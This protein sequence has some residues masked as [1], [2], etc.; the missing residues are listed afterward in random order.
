MTT[1]S[2]RAGV[3]AITSRWRTVDVDKR[4]V[5]HHRHLTGQL[6]QQ[7]HRTAQH[8]VEVDTGLQEA[9]DRPPLGRRQRLDVVDAV[10]ELAVALLGGHPPG[11]GVRLGDVAL[12]L[13][14]RHVVADG[15]AGHAQ[16]VPVDEGL[17]TDRFLG[18]DEVGNDGAQHLEATVVSTS[19]RLPPP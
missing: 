10:D 8:V 11:A 19:H 13:Q 18:G 7:P 3:T 9:L 6:S 14:H 4:R 16:V 12:G 2:S 17:R 15:G 1:I 5:L